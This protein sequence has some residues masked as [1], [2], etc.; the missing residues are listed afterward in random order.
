MKKTLITLV[1]AITVIIG[2]EVVKFK[3]TQNSLFLHYF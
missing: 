3:W 2:N 1:I